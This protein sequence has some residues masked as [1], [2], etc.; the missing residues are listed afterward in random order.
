M[1]MS[2]F[3]SAI[4]RIAVAITA[5]ACVMPPNSGV[6]TVQMIRFRLSRSGRGELLDDRLAKRRQVR[7]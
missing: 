5:M 6:K 7:R 3:R 1:S 4:S 2:A